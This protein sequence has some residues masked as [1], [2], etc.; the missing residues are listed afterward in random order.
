[1]ILFKKGEILDNA[2]LIIGNIA[3][4]GSQY[5]DVIIGTKG[6]I[7]KLCQ[8][9]LTTGN[10]RVDTWIPLWVISNLCR[11]VPRP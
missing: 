9:A 4:Q 11:G 2:L 3:G 5:R 7:D 8:T 6:F 1:M 10:Q